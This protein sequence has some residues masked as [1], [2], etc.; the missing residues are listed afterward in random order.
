M[1]LYTTGEFSTGTFGEFSTGIDT[2]NAL[3]EEELKIFVHLSNRYECLRPD[4][5][6]S[7]YNSQKDNEPPDENLD[8]LSRQQVDTI[9]KKLI[10]LRQELDLGITL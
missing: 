9:T 5:D 1:L 8:K 6:A 2:V 4:T 3:S 7:G 10:E